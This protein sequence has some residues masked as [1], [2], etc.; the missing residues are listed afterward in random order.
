MP[1]SDLLSI[2]KKKFEK[3]YVFSHWL[4]TL[5]KSVCYNDGEK[6][7]AVKRLTPERKFTMEQKK[8]RVTIWNEFRHEKKDPEARSHYP[9]GIHGRIAEILSECDDVE[10]RLA[11]LD[12][13][14]HGINDEVLDNTDVLIWWGHGAHDEVRDDRVEYIRWRV[15]N[16]MG[17]IASHSAHHS[18]PFKRLVGTSGNLSWGDNCHE[19]MWNL[20]PYH[21]IAAGIPAYFDLGIEELYAEPFSIPQPEEIIFGAWYE[22]GHV[23]RAGCTFSRGL[24]KIFYFQPGHESCDSYYNPYVAQIF[25]NA[26]HWAAPA[27]CSYIAPEGAPYIKPIV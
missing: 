22:S 15:C 13:P 6:R 23:F 10:I 8:I 24:G 9:K 20:N 3:T 7:R 5:T 19:I 25:K 2:W 21:P 17:F 27:R 12:E 4:L 11:S 18:K 26:V 1:I 16:G 14:D